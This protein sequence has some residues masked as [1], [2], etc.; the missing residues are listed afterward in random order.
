MPYAGPSTRGEREE[1]EEREEI[2]EKRKGTLDTTEEKGKGNKYE[3]PEWMAEKGSEY[4]S[5]EEKGKEDRVRRK[6]GRDKKSWYV[7][8]EMERG[9]NG[10]WW[11]WHW[12]ERE[13]TCERWKIYNEERKYFEIQGGK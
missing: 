8:N 11:K 3:K 6:M 5:G 2:R 12:K 13:N 1:G 4:R 10:A 7:R 9:G